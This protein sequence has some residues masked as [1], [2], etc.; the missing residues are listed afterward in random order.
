MRLLSRLDRKPHPLDKMD[1]SFDPIGRAQLD[2]HLDELVEYIT[3]PIHTPPNLGFLLKI[4]LRSKDLTIYRSHDPVPVHTIFPDTMEVNIDVQQT[5]VIMG[6]IS[7]V[8]DV[9]PMTSRNHFVD[10]LENNI[11]SDSVQIE[12]PSKLWIF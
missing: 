9:Y 7:L 1:Y 8:T 12:I 2:P 5:Q 4:H 6:R 11:I 3:R 10:T